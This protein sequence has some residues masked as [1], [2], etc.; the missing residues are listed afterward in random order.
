MPAIVNAPALLL[1]RGT[2]TAEITSAVKS[3]LESAKPNALQI[4]N[5]DAPD[6]STTYV[7]KEDKDGAWMVQ[8]ISVSGMVTTLLYATVLNNATVL[9]Y[10]AAWA[11]RATL[12]YGTFAEAF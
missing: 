12:T 1:P 2:T 5:V 9:T 11:A 3:A 8:K 10:N 4:N 7:G 6:S